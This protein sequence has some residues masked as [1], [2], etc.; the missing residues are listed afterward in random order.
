M[1]EI[2]ML[3][4]KQRRMYEFIRYNLESNDQAPTIMEI[5]HAVGMSSTGSVHAN[6][7]QIEHEGL[8]VR[9]RKHRGI[10]LPEREANKFMVAGREG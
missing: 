9:S 6:L 1:G 10:E 7:K 5:G 3:N 2:V 8:I 4:K